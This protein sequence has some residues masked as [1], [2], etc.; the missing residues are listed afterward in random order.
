[1]ISNSLLYWYQHLPQMINPVAVAIGFLSVRWYSL[2]Y[3]IGLFVVWQLVQWRIKKG[4]AKALQ[5][6][7]FEKTDIFFDFF[8]VSFVSGLVGG[9]IGYVLFYDLSFFLA[10]PMQIISPFDL[11]SGDFMGFYGMSYYGAL[12]TALLGALLFSKIRQIN[13]LTLAD[14]IVPA[15][16]AGYFFGRV[17]NFLNG[18]LFGRITTSKFGMYFTTS[19]EVLRYPSQLLEAFFEG[20]LLFAVLWKMRNQ[21][22]FKPGSLL[23]LYLFGYG[24]VRFFCEFFRQTDAQS[25]FIVDGLTMGQ[26]LSIVLILALLIVLF[27]KNRKSDII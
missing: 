23:L 27:F 18:E 8:L 11:A 15:L 24:A 20:I 16:P 1:M 12:I 17:G 2:M 10:H 3:L 4:E 25:G 6:K 19:P 5:N 14:F 26:I 9:R 21:K 22:R 13:F 7:K